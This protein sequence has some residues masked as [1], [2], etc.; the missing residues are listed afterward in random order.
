MGRDKGKSWIRHEWEA[1]AKRT[2]GP[3]RS[4][5][6]RIARRTSLPA[7]VVVSVFEAL[8]MEMRTAKTGVSIRGFGIFTLIRRP[9]YKN[10]KRSVVEIVFRPSP[11]LLKQLAGWVCEDTDFSEVAGEIYRRDNRDGVAPVPRG[12][13]AWEK[14]IKR[15]ERRAEA[16][17]KSKLKAE[18]LRR[19]DG[20]SR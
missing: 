15:R 9:S 12:G 17:S 10:K 19:L 1:Y 14:I 5:V 6:L 8:L 20:N 18:R 2:S 3:A 16:A 11:I 13:Q 4:G 7:A